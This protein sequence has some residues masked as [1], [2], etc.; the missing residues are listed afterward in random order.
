[1]A[2]GGGELEGF[3]DGAEGLV[4]GVAT[5]PLHLRELVEDGV[6][7]LDLLGNGKMFEVVVRVGD[8]A[9]GLAEAEAEVV[10]EDLEGVLGQVLSDEGA[11]G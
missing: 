4:E 6:E 3:G 11:W 8:E 9:V 7:E 1:M 5:S 2:Q 10:A